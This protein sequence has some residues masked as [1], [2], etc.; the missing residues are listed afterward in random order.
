[1]ALAGPTHVEAVGTIFRGAAS[2]RRRRVT[3]LIETLPLSSLLASGFE[4]RCAQL[5][6][7]W[8]QYRSCRG[9]PGAQY[10]RVLREATRLPVITSKQVSKTLGD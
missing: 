7:F 4:L 1:V 5:I 8:A 2:G 10:R 9:T 6:L 3:A